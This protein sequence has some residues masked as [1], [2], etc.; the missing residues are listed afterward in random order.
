ME[1]FDEEWI[2]AV[3]L[4]LADLPAVEGA[5][6]VVDYVVAGAPAGKTTIGVVIEGGKVTAVGLGKSPDPDLVISMKYDA[7]LRILTGEMTSDAGYMNGALKVEGTHERWMLDLRPTR[8][9]AVQA[10]ASVMDDSTT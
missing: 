3:A 8:R 7:A 4:A 6:A 5:D 9:A 2:A 10:L 1:I